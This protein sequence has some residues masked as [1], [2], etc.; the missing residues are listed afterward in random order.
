MLRPHHS[1]GRLRHRRHGHATRRQTI[2]ARRPGL[3]HQVSHL[4][5][6][7]EKDDAAGLEPAAS[8][9]RAAAVGHVGQG[10]V[11]A[12]VNARQRRPLRRRRRP[13][14]RRGAPGRGRIR[15]IAPR[16]SK[17]RR[18]RRGG[19][20]VTSS[21]ATLCCQVLRLSSRNSRGRPPRRVFDKR[22]GEPRPA[23][24]L[25]HAVMPSRR[26]RSSPYST[27]GPESLLP[28][29]VFFR[30]PSPCVGPRSARR[31]T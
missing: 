4:Q 16:R 8:A 28:V 20:V 25:Y 26:Y 18:G 15:G 13:K 3:R 14:R 11:D 12:Q 5:D 21:F 22:G 19:R 17:S 9:A 2:G 29:P 27:P 30:R 31:H 1:R 6:A 23:H 10:R 24:L 7:R